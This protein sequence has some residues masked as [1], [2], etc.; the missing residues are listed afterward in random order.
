MS[1]C[2]VTPRS[3]SSVAGGSSSAAED[4]SD[5]LFL[6]FND[7]ATFHLDGLPL[8]EFD[9]ESALDALEGFAVSTS[10]SLVRNLERASLAPFSSTTTCTCLETLTCKLC[11]MSFFSSWKHCT[12]GGTYAFLCKMGHHPTGRQV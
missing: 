9:D 10:K 6:L 2:P 7:E 5:L 4:P 1:S 12:C 11:R 8:L 3:D